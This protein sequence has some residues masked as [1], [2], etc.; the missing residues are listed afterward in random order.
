MELLDDSRKS[1]VVRYPLKVAVRF[2]LSPEDDRGATNIEVL[3]AKFAGVAGEC[4]EG[5]EENG[6]ST[7]E[8]GDEVEEE[9]Q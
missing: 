7:V 9:R 5:Q 6:K 4:V 3:Y 1:R 2:V 8:E